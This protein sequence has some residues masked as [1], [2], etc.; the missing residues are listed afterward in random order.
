MKKSALA[1]LLSGLLFCAAAI[2]LESSLG[3]MPSSKSG[4]VGF[5]QWD[6]AVFTFSIV[7]AVCF[8]TAV[9][10]AIYSMVK[11]PQ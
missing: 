9:Y 5:V 6:A 3:S 10:M 1:Y 4:S 7:A 11:A 2:G 8:L